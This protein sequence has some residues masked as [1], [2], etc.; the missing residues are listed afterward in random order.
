MLQINDLPIE[1]QFTI[2]EL[3][4]IS[5]ILV[6]R[7]VCKHWRIVLSGIKIEELI[8]RHRN[9]RS[10]LEAIEWHFERV[11]TRNVIAVENNL[12]LN[13]LRST[14]FNLKYLKRLMIRGV[15][16]YDEVKI[17]LM[18]KFANLEILEMDEWNGE[19]T[20][21]VLPKLK[22]LYLCRIYTGELTID[23][24]KLESVLCKIGILRINLQHNES[25]KHLEIFTFRDKV[26]EFTGLETLKLDHTNDAV[27]NIL[28]QLPKLREIQF[29]LC[30]Y[31]METF[32]N[33]IST[34]SNLVVERQ[35]LNRT[36]LKIFF[37]DE[38]VT[39]EDQVKSF[40]PEDFF[41]YLND[42]ELDSQTGDSED[43][44]Y[45]EDSFRGS[46]SDLASSDEFD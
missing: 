35:H 14:M 7:L 29:T 13:L 36:N 8:F 41:D 43:Y 21:L 12:A 46:F 18:N 27:Q 5:D 6:S 40:G 1:I 17:E 22:S 10:V 34:I 25:L 44:V 16:N 2:F 45:Y 42:D 33:T 26:L 38:L 30:D 9:D 23:S 3:L 39:S 19:G 31:E 37:K 20:K 11:P 28:M 24:P 15:L 4:E 32:D